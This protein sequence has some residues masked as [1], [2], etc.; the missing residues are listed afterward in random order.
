MCNT[1]E[2]LLFFR[3]LWGLPIYN[4]QK[5]ND[6]PRELWLCSVELPQVGIPLLS[7]P[8][9]IGPFTTRPCLSAQQAH[10]EAAEMA[11]HTLKVRF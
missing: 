9:A 6:A 5:V 3:Y 2:N 10:V 7:V 8:Q 1:I 4:Y 11:L